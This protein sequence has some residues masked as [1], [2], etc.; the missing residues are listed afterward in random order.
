MK[1]FAK[2]TISKQKSF[3]ILIAVGFATNDFAIVRKKLTIKSRHIEI[4]TLFS[5][6]I[7]L[8]NCVSSFSNELRISSVIS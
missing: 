2:L 5:L 8:R 6:E 3:V 4:A 7:P 1:Y